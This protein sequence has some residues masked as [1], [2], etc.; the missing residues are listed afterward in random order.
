MLGDGRLN[1]LLYSTGLRFEGD[2]EAETRLYITFWDFFIQVNGRGN[3]VLL[4][5]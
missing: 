1:G 4:V 2:M 3:R 5:L